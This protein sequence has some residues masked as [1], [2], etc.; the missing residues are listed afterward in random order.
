MNVYVVSSDG[1]VPR[2]L[3]WEPTGSQATGW[4]PDGKD[5]LFTSGHASKSVYPRPFQSSRRRRRARPSVAAAQRRL[6]QLFQRRQYARL[7]TGAPV[8]GG[9][10]AL[11]RRPDLAGVAGQHEDARS[12]KNP[13]RKF[14]RLE[15]RVDRQHRCTSYPTA[16]DRFRCSAYD[17]TTKQVQQVLENHGL[18]SE[19]LSAGPAA[20]VYEQFGSLH[21][22]D[23]ASRQDHAVPVSIHGDLPRLHRIW[24][25]LVPESAVENIA[26][27]PTGARVVV[28]A[29]GDIFTLPAEKGDIR[30]LTNTPGSAERDPSWSPDGKSIAYFSDASGEYQLYIRDQDGLSA[31]EGHRS[32]SEPLVLLLPAL[33]AGLQAHRLRRQASADLVCRCRRRQAGEDRHGTARRLRRRHAAF[34]VA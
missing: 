10:E 11:S 30:N 34:L 5:V 16:M 29:R 24:L 18:D 1:G 9:L 23:P 3:T 13:A 20:L 14:Q 4:T 2:R 19:D 22:Y 6:G 12:G 8:A 33:V 27:S 25:A 28:E 7:R 17:T 21:L 32:G 15:P 26:V 31:A